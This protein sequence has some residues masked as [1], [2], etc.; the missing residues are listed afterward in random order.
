M[1][2]FRLDPEFRDARRQAY[3]EAPAYFKWIFGGII[4]ALFL[5]LMVFAF[6]NDRNQQ[7]AANQR[8]GVA[9]STPGAG[10]RAP[11]ETTGSGA[12]N[13]PALPDAGNTRP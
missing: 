12:V 4:G 10:M 7:T 3:E 13:R 9:K 2:D 6:T 1:S 8:P 11:A 5:G